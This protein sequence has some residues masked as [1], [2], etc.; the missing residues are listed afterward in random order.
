MNMLNDYFEQVGL[1]LSSDQEAKLS[2][3]VDL[4][5]A[6]N[7][8]LNLARF[9][10]RKEFLV[11][12]ILDSLMA[13]RFMNLKAGMKVADIG[14][15]GGF[16]GIPL[17]ILHPEVEFTLIDSVQK[18][19]TAVQEFADTLGLPNVSTLSGR[20]E[21]IGHSDLRERFDVVVARA[22]APL[23]VLLELATPLVKVGGVFVSLKGPGYLEEIIEADAAT[24]L[25][26]LPVP[27]AERYDLPDDMGKRYVV[28]FEKKK[29]TPPRF[30]RRDGM[31]KKKP[32]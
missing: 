10:D 12:H 26:K 13:E 7:E 18:K 4:F 16:P 15:G 24:Q 3:F 20:L 32:L 11:K 29:P 14:T 27:T 19:I 17:A 31:P 5:L 1:D 30:P 2:Q 23:P 28:T 8:E 21:A 9:S 22:L 6:K 25:L